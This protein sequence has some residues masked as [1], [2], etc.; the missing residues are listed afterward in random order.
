MIT[1]AAWVATVLRCEGTPYLH[2]GRAPG[3]GLDCAGPL[4]WAARETGLRGAEFDV[5]G[6]PRQPDG[7]LQPYLEAELERVPRE[8]LGLGDVVLNAYRLGPPRHLAIIVGEAWGQWVLLHASSDTGRVQRE[9]L[10]Y[11]RRF[12]RYVAGYHVPG[13]AV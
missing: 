10:Q 13:V 12:Y 9:R 7:S 4:I 2:Q 6:Y 3:I 8:A 5:N 1:R 11:E